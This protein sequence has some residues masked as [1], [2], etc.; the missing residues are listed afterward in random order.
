MNFFNLS[1]AE[2]EAVYFL[3]ECGVLPSARICSNNHLTKLYFGNVNIRNDNWFAK[4][5][6]LFMTA[7]RFIYGWSNEMT[8]IKWCEQEL[9]KSENTNN[10]LHEVCAMAIENK[11]QGKIG[12]P[13]KI[14]E[15]D[16]SLFSKRKNHVG[17]VLPKQWILGGICRE[18]K[19][20]ELYL[21]R[22]K[23]HSG[24]YHDLFRLLACI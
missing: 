18:T 2:K 3:Q 20:Q 1:S 11:P 10:Y 21:Q 9:N 15:I 4:S 16:E 13:G 17:R 5:R 14:V 8:S 23:Q 22:S 6:I 19:K 7:V 24:R 12:R